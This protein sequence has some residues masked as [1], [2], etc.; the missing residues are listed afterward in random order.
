MLKKQLARKN[1]LIIYCFPNQYVLAP[2]FLQFL[3]CPF[4]FQSIYYVF[5][6][7]SIQT[8][9]NIPIQ[10]FNALR[11]QKILWQ[12]GVLVLS[13]LIIR[14]KSLQSL[15]MGLSLLHKRSDMAALLEKYISI[16]TLRK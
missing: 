6:T 10:D 3:H 2:T 8:L 11:A 9:S 5:L 14:F 15:L 1:R 7:I 4:F 12:L 13:R 16:K